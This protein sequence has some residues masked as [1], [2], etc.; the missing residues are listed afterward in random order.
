MGVSATTTAEGSQILYIAMSGSA[1]CDH[2]E[3]AAKKALAY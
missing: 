1:M 2:I 3:H